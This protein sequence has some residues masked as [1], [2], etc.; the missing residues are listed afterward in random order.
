MTKNPD[1]PAYLYGS[2]V[3]LTAAPQTGYHFAGWSGDLSGTTNP[4]QI[5]M[6]GAKS[7]TANFAVSAPTTPTPTSPSDGST[8]RPLSLS[9]LWNKTSL[10]QTY[11]IQVSISSAFASIFK[12][13]SSLTDTSYSP[14]GLANNSG[15][16]WHVRAANAGG[17]SDWSRPWKFTTIV[18]F[19]AVVI[20]VAPAKGDTVVADSVNLI[21]HKTDSTVLRYWLE[22]SIDSTF[23]GAKIDSLLVDTAT[24]IKSFVNKQTCWWRVRAYNAAGWGAFSDKQY[25]KVAI[26][27][28][29][30]LAK[31]YQL[32]LHSAYLRGSGRIIGYSLPRE[33]QVSMQLYDLHGNHVLS[34]VNSRQ[35]AG[36]HAASFDRQLLPDGNYILRFKAS[37]FEVNRKL[38][39]M[40]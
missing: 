32:L 33:S 14:S 26:P 39:I 7:V 2:L 30:I 34:L 28:V 35:P 27:T 5:S 13:N 10:A 3:L 40:Q 23:T 12:E 29:N 24:V 11:H 9:L 19:P 38:T 21:W 31:N 36:S 22:T 25:F 16:F 18:A 17:A 6:N 8:G 1:Q 37:A 4:S 20:T 15:Y